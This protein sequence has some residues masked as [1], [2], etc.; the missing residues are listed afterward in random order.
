MTY[1]PQDTALGTLA[2]AA[3]AA[4]WIT[5][6]ATAVQTCEPGG[7]TKQEHLGEHTP[8]ESAHYPRHQHKGQR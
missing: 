2:V 1:R 6:F 7:I 5:C 8:P 3:T 4:I